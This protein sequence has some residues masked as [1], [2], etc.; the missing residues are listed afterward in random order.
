[1]DKLKVLAPTVKVLAIPLMVISGVVLLAL[2]LLQYSYPQIESKMGEIQQS[3]VTYQTL[4]DR[5]QVLNRFQSDVLGDKS[6]ISFVVLPDK[7]PGAITLSQIKSKLE[8][9]GAHVKNVEFVSSGNPLT[10]GVQ[11]MDLNI[12]YESANLVSSA[13][14]LT[15]LST[16]APITGLYEAEMSFQGDKYVTKLRTSVYWSPLPQE[17]PPLTEPLNDLTE[18][19][20]ILLNKFNSYSFPVFS[21]LSAD[22]PNTARENPFN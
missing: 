2:F 16:I 13:E 6:D 4:Q 15:S 18:A 11:T 12:E 8:G 17:L 9:I 1:M 10:N 21:S 3:N 19:D 7:N 5:L 22:Q 20:K 14:V